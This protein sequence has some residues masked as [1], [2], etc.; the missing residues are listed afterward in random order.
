VSASVQAVQA[1]KMPSRVGYG[2][3]LPS[4]LAI[5]VAGLLGVTLDAVGR[6]PRYGRSDLS[7]S[8][9]RFG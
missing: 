9:R 7:R 8:S 4:S 1:L 3:E 6:A 5:V 2:V